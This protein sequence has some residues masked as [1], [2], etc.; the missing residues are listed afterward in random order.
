M[1]NL[2][3]FNL[4]LNNKEELIDPYYHLV[5]NRTVIPFTKEK[6]NKLTISNQ[7]VIRYISS[8]QTMIQIGKSMDSPEVEEILN[9]IIDELN[10][11]GMNLSA[12]SQYFNVHN[13]NY[14]VFQSLKYSEKITVLKFVIKE[15]IKNRHELYVNHGYSN[16]VL[17]VMSDNYSHKRKGTYGTN[18]IISILKLLD[19]CHINEM[20]FGSFEKEKY[21][22]L[23]DK[24]DKKL[25]IELAKK[26][27]IKIHSKDKTT[28]KYPDAFIK[29]GDDYFIVEQKN[30]KETGGG[31]DKQTLEI[32]DF[33]D[34]QPEFKK[35]HYI[36]FLDGIYFNNIDNNSAGKTSQQYNDIVSAL[37]KFPDNFF[38]NSYKTYQRL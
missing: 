4:S 5:V 31:Q 23:P 21:Y 18:K 16:I 38:V 28:E 9:L 35:L 15:Y 2:D 29:T 34:R 37:Y 25:Y 6:N 7:N 12:F 30:M 36:T 13:M 3:Y 22:L 26:Y 20:P 8:V 14:S 17:Q 19:I 11:P 33:I 27:G 1:N 24:K 32:T 10:T